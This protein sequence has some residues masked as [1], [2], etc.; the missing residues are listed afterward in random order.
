MNFPIANLFSHRW[1][2]TQAGWE[3]ARYNLME[4]PAQGFKPGGLF[5]HADGRLC[6][7]TRGSDIFGNAIPGMEINGGVATIP[8]KGVIA[9]NIGAWEKNWGFVD[10]NDLDHELELAAGSPKVDEIRLAFDSPGGY[11]VG[12]PDLA[13]KIASIN[14]SEKEVNAFAL[15]Q[16]CSAA[17]W[18]AAGAYSITA[19]KTS[20]V[21]SI[22][23]YQPIED[24]SRMYKN[25]GV[26]V[27]LIKSGEFKGQGYPGTPY[28]E[29]YKAHLQA[30]VDTLFG[31]FAGHVTSNRLGVESDSMKGQSFLGE[32]AFRRG[33]V[34]IVI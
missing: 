20:D 34:D 15:G 21:G 18:L 23:V 6:A 33:L 12:V 19:G 4:R 1:A 26:D 2:I 3:T 32:E 9:A 13:E 31:W 28:S 30:E 22:G 29:E 14:E 17:Y 27:E 7:S 10:V 8:I 25:A 24:Y 11:I 5:S 16:C